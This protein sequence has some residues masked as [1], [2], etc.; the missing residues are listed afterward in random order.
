MLQS[1]LLRFSLLRMPADHHEPLDLGVVELDLVRHVVAG[2]RPETALLR[3]GLLVATV[4][5]A[6]RGQPSRAVLPATGICELADTTSEL[7]SM[8]AS[9]AS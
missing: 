2:D 4:N 9:P 8:T 3:V 6:A 1:R 7:P 5:R